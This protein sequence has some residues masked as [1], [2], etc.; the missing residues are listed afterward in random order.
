MTLCFGIAFEDYTQSLVRRN[1][2]ECT[3]SAELSLAQASK[4]RVL[5]VEEATGRFTP[6]EVASP[7]VVVQHPSHVR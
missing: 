4:L 1:S 3:R 6:G 5:L 2:L 7:K